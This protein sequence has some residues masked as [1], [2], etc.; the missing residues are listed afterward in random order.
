MTKTLLAL[1]AATGLLLPLASGAAADPL[2]CVVVRDSS[3]NAVD[4]VCLP[5]PGS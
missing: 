2:K 3:G 1:A 5:V 4:T